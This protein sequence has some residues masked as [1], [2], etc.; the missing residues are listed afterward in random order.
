MAGSHV[1]IENVHV[2]KAEYEN[3]LIQLNEGLDVLVA[4]M[5]MKKLEKANVIFLHLWIKVYPALCNPA[6]CKG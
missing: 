1:N 5:A 3:A 2:Q 4:V 6:L